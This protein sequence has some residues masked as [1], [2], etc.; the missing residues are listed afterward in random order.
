MAGVVGA[1][2]L[3]AVNAPTAEAAGSTLYMH[4]NAAFTMDNTAPT[5]A[6][7]A[8][9]LLTVGATRTWATTTATTNA[10]TIFAS[11][12][13]AFQ[14]WTTGAGG[15]TTV[16][17]T[18]AYSSSSTCSSPTTIAQSSTTL[19]SGSG[20]TT[21]GFSPASNVTVP[22]GSFFCFTLAVTAQAGLN[23]TLDYDAAGSATNLASTQT[24]FI[25]EL[26]LPLL[27]LALLI[28]AATRR[29][30]S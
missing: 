17:L 23:L 4:G 6:L 19:T 29:R 5:A 13:L 21:P 20:L 3:G 1:L 11:T 28:P 27:G 15:T 24:I 26:V 25:P 30:W 16:T 9:L 14:Y 22:A 8:S 12:S 18:F 2:V 7:P 10:Q